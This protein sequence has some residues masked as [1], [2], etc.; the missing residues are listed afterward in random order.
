MRTERASEDLIQ[1]IV[2]D[3]HVLNAEITNDRV[4]LGPGF[5]VGHS[6]FCGGMSPAGATASWYRDVIASE[7]SPLL[8]EYWFDDVAKAEEWERRLLSE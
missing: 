5:C 6:Y 1:R 4:N 2:R 7:G 3:M 8:K